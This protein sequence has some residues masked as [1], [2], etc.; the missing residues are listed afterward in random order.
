M[1]DAQASSAKSGLTRGKAILIGLLGIV[2]LAVLYVQFGRHEKLTAGEHAAYRPPR[3]LPAK[4]AGTAAANA[5]TH[6]TSAAGPATNGAT[7]VQVID[8]SR[9]KSPELTKVIAY[10]PFKLPDTFPQPMRL[11][12]SGKTPSKAD[13]AAAAKADDANKRTQALGKLQTRMK[14]L[15]QRGV[16]VIVGE[17]DQ[18]AAMIDDRMLHVGDKID[19]FTVIAIDDQNGVVI[20]RKDSP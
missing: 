14:E 17:G 4:P 7:P 20:E 9:W 11:A 19:G 12:S 6:L 8:E 13:L 5:A 15:K 18:Y 3:R 10:D 2:L 16:T 1:A